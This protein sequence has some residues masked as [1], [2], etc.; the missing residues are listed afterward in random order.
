MVYTDHA[1][2][3]KK[4]FDTSSID[5][6]VRVVIGSTRARSP[7]ADMQRALALLQAGI[8]DRLEVIMGL[9]GG[10]NKEALMNRLGEIQNLSGQVQQLEEQNK[11]L[12]ELE[13][14][15]KRIDELEK[16][17]YL[18]DGQLEELKKQIIKDLTDQKT[19]SLDVELEKIKKN[20]KK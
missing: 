7:L 18:Q 9:T 1:E 13:E 4:L 15:S 3:V 2:S 17:F 11:K 6:D 10:E 12:N 16:K 5:A 20:S 19:N 14:K 8:Y